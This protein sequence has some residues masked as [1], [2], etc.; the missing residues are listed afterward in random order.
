MADFST[1]GTALQVG[2]AA[3][4]EVFTTIADITSVSDLGVTRSS[5]DTTK[6]NSNVRTSKAG[7][8]SVPDLTIEGT[9]DG[10]NA[11]V[12]G[13][14]TNVTTEDQTDRNWKLNIDVSPAEVWSFS[15]YVGE[16]MLLG[17]QP[18]NLH[19]FRATLRINTVPTLGAT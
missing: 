2:D 3:S 4:P 18:D 13:L 11:T 17:A 6:L 9:Y 7:L 10:N 1:Q 5:L 12:T 15:A 8:P 14:W 19:R 16:F